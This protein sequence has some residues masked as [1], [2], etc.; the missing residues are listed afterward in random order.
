MHINCA[1]NNFVFNATLQKIRYD[2]SV[3][4]VTYSENIWGA[5]KS[6]IMEDR[7]YDLTP[8]AES[9]SVIDDLLI[10]NAMKRCFSF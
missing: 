1:D 7:F 8:P 3:W 5:H 2:G 6:S 4:E 10:F 9:S